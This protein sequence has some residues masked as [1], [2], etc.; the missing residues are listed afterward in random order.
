MRSGSMFA[1][2]VAWARG[3]HV[4]GLMVK[5]LLLFL[6]SSM[7]I[8]VVVVLKTN[9]MHRDP[10]NELRVSFVCLCCGIAL[11]TVLWAMTLSQHRS[12]AFSGAHF[13]LLGV[14]CAIL[15]ICPLAEMLD[16]LSRPGCCICWRSRAQDEQHLMDSDQHLDVP[17]PRERTR[18]APK[19]ADGLPERP[20]QGQARKTARMRG[21]LGESL[22]RGLRKLSIT[23]I[24]R[25]VLATWAHLWYLTEVSISPS[26]TSLDWLPFVA[27]ALSLVCAAM[28][29][30]DI[31]L[32][33]WVDD[34][35]V[36]ANKKWITFYYFIELTA[37]LPPLVYL[38]YF[39]QSIA[40]TDPPCFPAAW[41]VIFG[42]DVAVIVL[43]LL[44]SSP[45]LW[46]RGCRHLWK[47]LCNRVLQC[48]FLAI[49]LF[50]FNLVMFDPGMAF[51]RVNKY[52]TFIRL[53]ELIAIF[54]S[55]YATAERIDD[56]SSQ[57]A[58]F[59]T[60]LVV[61]MAVTASVASVQAL[62]VWWVIPRRRMATLRDL[63]ESR[64]GQGMPGQ[65]HEGAGRTLGSDLGWGLVGDDDTGGSICSPQQ[66]TTVAPGG[67]RPTLLGR[68][69]LLDRVG[70][71]FECL[72]LVSKAKSRR[73][74]VRLLQN[75]VDELWLAALDWEGTYIE[76]G[77]GDIITIELEGRQVTAVRTAAVKAEEMPSAGA[78]M[79][80]MVGIIVGQHEIQ[81][82][83]E[84]AIFTGHFNSERIDWSDGSIWQKSHRSYDSVVSV[85]KVM[86]LLLPQLVLACRWECFDD[87]TLQDDPASMATTGPAV[88]VNSDDNPLTVFL[89]RYAFVI[90]DRRIVSDTYWRLFALSEA[91]AD[92]RRGMYRRAKSLLLQAMAGRVDFVDSR[93]RRL[94][95]L[96]DA[97]FAK[98]CADTRQYLLNQSHLWTQTRDLHIAL[99]AKRSFNSDKSELLRRLLERWNSIQRTKTRMSLRKS[100]QPEMSA[101][102]VEADHLLLEDTPALDQPVS[103]VPEAG[104]RN[105]VEITLPI[106]PD[107]AFLGV[108]VD[109]CRVMKS[110]MEPF[111]LTCRMRP[112]QGSET[113]GDTTMNTEADT[114]APPVA[115]I[116]EYMVK[117]GDDLR[118]D[119]LITQL[120][121]LMQRA[122]EEGLPKETSRLL[123]LAPY[124]VLAVTPK[125]G[126]IKF[127]PNSK[128]LA[129]AL[130]ESNWD[131]VAYFRQSAAARG[132]PL[133]AVLDRFMG[134]VAAFSVATYV[135]GIGDRHL[136]NLM[137]TDS[138][139]FFHVDFGF[140]LGD[141]PKPGAPPLRLPREIVTALHYADSTAPTGRYDRCFALAGEAF[142]VLRNRCTL[143]TSMVMLTAAAGG[144]GVSKLRSERHANQAVAGIV[145]RLHMDQEDGD[146]IVRFFNVMRDAHEALYPMIMDKMHQVG[147]FWH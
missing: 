84:A 75:V 126:Y 36:K 55:I 128:P 49:P 42:A 121:S 8:V 89:I 122:W 6:Q 95:W 88:V 60:P 69:S 68:A 120:M 146:A 130:R 99:K 97:S 19:S 16:K 79:T 132:L 57:W 123:K 27:S 142:Q 48:V 41:L 70:D 31:T 74:R 139:F 145:E 81:L 85:K 5:A 77:S 101:P 45:A 54:V 22:M 138:G 65:T 104:M 46:N 117:W 64:G 33:V 118:Q 43:L 7:D 136:D 116:E 24:P 56:Q 10:D 50:I 124:K 4:P 44:S 141:D 76:E 35:F 23:N 102:L 14:A 26:N 37:R 147:L 13:G 40:C 80:I 106:E 25:A 127:V 133:S 114:S 86:P 51:V 1:S 112:V 137:V 67:A 73:N 93:R 18:S 134:S 98:F 61:E 17:T 11:S 90:R 15:Q 119:Q 34:Q 140:V 91:E 32:Y 129:K 78:P 125:A 92:E 9:A 87:D 52:Y 83:Q 62:F 38:Q 109:Q 113:V 58:P 143:W 28:G 47:Q 2:P 108:E 59:R 72:L 144:G 12:N 82:L 3:S 105:H 30:A 103:L 53:A 66:G 111:V 131:L 21:S 110:A 135:L 94:A 63:L 100:E 29:C 71:I 107:K 115:L 39:F 96:T 20:S